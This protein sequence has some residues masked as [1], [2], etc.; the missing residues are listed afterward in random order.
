VAAPV[1]SDDDR[2]GRLGYIAA[3]AASAIAHV[4]IVLIVL[5]V[6]PSLFSSAPIAPVAYTVKVV[7]SI[8]A[9]DL[10]TRLPRLD[11]SHRHEPP[12]PEAKREE[13]PKPPEE[14]PPAPPPSDDK[15]ALALNSIK[16]TST[17]TP[18]PT[19]TPTPTS[20]E[21]PAPTPAETPAP[22]PPSPSPTPRPHR[23][24]RPKPKPRA[25]PRPSPK[26]RP[27]PTATPIAMAWAEPTPDV[28]ERLKKVREQLLAE[29]LKEMSSENDADTAA[30]RNAKP[31]ANPS[32]GPVV[33]DRESPG[34]GYGVGPGS[35]S[36]GIQQDPDFLLYYQDVQERIK[37][38]WS[39]DGN[40]PD[41]TATVTFGIN[42]DGSLN[43]V[44]VTDT[45]RDPAFDDSV[46]RAIRRAAPFGPPPGKYQSQFAGG[47][48]AVFKL[49]DLDS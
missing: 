14:K 4:A 43:A 21:T 34:K 5:F 18:T 40:N 26:A 36:A 11:D 46:V 48:E 35:G 2:P 30:A 24:P 38:A 16:A 8:P 19:P 47:V 10:G 17:A 12:P 22:P 6:L 29:H 49:S 42:P 25:T 1:L 20:E 7:D 15:N 27:Q 37:K 9:G 39:F 41:L 45:S 23:T 13:P 3:I 31:I 44:K 28:Q 32:G 33:A